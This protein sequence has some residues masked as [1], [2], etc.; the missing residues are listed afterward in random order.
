VAPRAD[1]DPA[2]PGDDDPARPDLDA[3]IR[4]LADGGP[5]ARDRAAR[6][7]GDRRDRR[8]IPALTVAMESGR[9][10]RGVVWALTQFDDPATAAP[11]AAALS[12]PDA[13]ARAMAAG[14]LADLGDRGAVP[15]LLAA[16]A[17]EDDHVREEVARALGRVGDPVA[18][19][20]VLAALRD[21]PG[22]HVREEAATAAG[23]LVAA[24]EAAPDAPPRD[25][26]PA[27]ARVAEV[28][29]ALVDALG[30]RH[31]TVRR[32]A[33]E[34]LARMGPASRARL[35][36]LASGP[37]ARGRDEAAGA[38]AALEAGRLSPAGPAPRVPKR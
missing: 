13:T 10:G 7:L 16:L 27:D 6:D 33:A 19:G 37:P 1:D 15:A 28:E 25:A 32:A 34:A 12:E 11:L 36:A 9:G 21:D 26:A 4:T 18:L 31:V 3:L 30:D 20:A 2:R 23:A 8:A 29:A 5:D 14:R 38:L 22:P 17:D 35:R 24:E